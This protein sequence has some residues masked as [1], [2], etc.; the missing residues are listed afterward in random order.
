[1]KKVRIDWNNVQGGWAPTHFQVADTADTAVLPAMSEA[2]GKPAIL[3]C[4]LEIEAPQAGLAFLKEATAY[5][6]EILLCLRGGYAL[7]QEAYEAAVL[8][9]L[10]EA[11]ALC[12]NLRYIE[13]GNETALS[14]VSDEAYYECYRGAYHALAK[15]GAPLQLGGNGADALLN[16]ADSWLAFLTNL[17]E[18]TDPQKRIDFYSFHDALRDYPVRVWLSHE[19]HIAWLAELGLPTLPIFI[20]ELT[21]TPREELNGGAELN[22]RNAASMITAVISATEW[23][24]F[25]LFLKS[26]LDAE[27]AYTQFQKQGDRFRTTPNAH[28]ARML[29]MLGGEQLVCDIIEE[30]W[31]PHK[32]IAA[33]KKDGVVTVLVTNPTDEPTYIKFTLAYI[34][35]KKLKVKEYRVDNRHNAAGAPLTLT[36]GMYQ[37]PTK[38]KNSE[39]VEMLGGHDTREELDGTI[40]VECN[41]RENAFCLWTFEPYA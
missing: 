26:A 23:P 7:S 6:E 8:P 10:Q 12:P 38:I 22:L 1:M 2:Y 34:P 41:L 9:I 24:E 18:D 21:L 13:I 37:A 4:T 25:R 35:Y 16:R 36:D 3:R 19:A 27:P 31:P 11:C 15:L 28:A 14:G 33:T 30:S 20:S 17:A 32:D 39:N 5:A 29:A 40:T